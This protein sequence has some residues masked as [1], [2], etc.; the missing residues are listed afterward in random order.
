MVAYG[1]G[2]SRPALITYRRLDRLRRRPS[3]AAEGPGT[4]Q[5]IQQQIATEGRMA[6]GLSQPEDFLQMSTD[7]WHSP[8]S[9][10]QL[11]LSDFWSQGRNRC[12]GAKEVLYRKN[13]PAD[14]VYLIRWGLVKLLSYLPNG[15]VRILRLR[16]ANQWLGY[17]G[18]LGDAYWHTAVA[19]DR[20]EA[21]CFQTGSLEELEQAQPRQ[22]GQFMRQWCEDVVQADRWIADFSTGEIKPRVA[23]LLQYLAELECS[24]PV[25]QVKLLTVQEMAEILGVTQESVSRILAG[26]KRSGILQRQLHKPDP[27][28]GQALR[29]TY[30]VDSDKLRQEA[31][32]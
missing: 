13:E 2:S 32:R 20:T 4:Q 30:R 26:F 7:A 17:E 27:D 18:Q 9:R 5:Q 3:K 22:F 29:E 19:V 23:R 8:V 11:P 31:F 15:Q 28:T 25:S 10:Q 1:L 16:A 14:R 21:Y 24:H 12:F 6:E